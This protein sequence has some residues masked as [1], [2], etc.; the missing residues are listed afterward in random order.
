MTKDASAE[1][2]DLATQTLVAVAGAYFLYPTLVESVV[3]EAVEQNDA[4]A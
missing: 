3:I 2:L 4:Q 1:W